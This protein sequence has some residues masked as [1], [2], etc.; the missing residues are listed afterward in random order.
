MIRRPPRSTLFPYTTLFRSRPGA[1]SGPAPPRAMDILMRL[2]TQ[3]PAFDPDGDLNVVIE[4]PKGSHNKYAYDEEFGTF[5]FKAVMPEGNLFPHDFGFVPSTLGGDGDPLDVLVLL[6]VSL[7]VGCLLSARPLGVIEAEQRERNGKTERNDRLLAV[8][9]KARTHAHVHRLE[10]LRP[11]L[12]DEIEAFFGHYNALSGRSF[13]PVGRGGPERAR[14]LVEAGIA[15]QRQRG[16]CGA[17][18]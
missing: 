15:A 4:T 16:G 1:L 5:R 13:T 3:I 2:L 7:P 12:L 6:D 11:G 10:D 17:A 8:A 14:E 18:G 9:T